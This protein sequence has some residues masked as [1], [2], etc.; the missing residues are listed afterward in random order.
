MLDNKYI[1]QELSPFKGRSVGA[2]S[3]DK[4]K[5]HTGRTFREYKPRPGR[6]RLIPHLDPPE[7]TEHLMQQGVIN[8]VDKGFI[9]KDV[10]V[11]PAFER[12]CPSIV[13]RRMKIENAK[14]QIRTFKRITDE[15]KG[16]ATV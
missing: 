8:L 16:D 1:K 5:I 10:D 11:T 6:Q 4:S 9:T 14:D 13:S 12:G 3:N 7:I 15:A 2:T